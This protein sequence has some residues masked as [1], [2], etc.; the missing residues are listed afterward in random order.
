M[1]SIIFWKT[2]VYI[3]LPFMPRYIGTLNVTH[4]DIVTTGETTPPSPLDITE[5][6]LSPKAKSPLIPPSTHTPTRTITPL[7]EVQIDKNRHVTPQPHEQTNP[8]QIIPKWLLGRKTSISTPTSPVKQTTQPPTKRP[9]GGATTINY[10]LQEQ[11][12]REVFSPRHRRHKKTKSPDPLTTAVPTAP[13]PPIS[14]LTTDRRP[15]QGL[16]NMQSLPSLK[17]KVEEGGPLGRGHTSSLDLRKVATAAPSR[18]DT[19]PEKNP[20]PDPTGGTLRRRYSAGNL[21]EHSEEDEEKVPSEE[22]EEHLTLKPPTPP[23]EPRGSV[24]VPTYA[25]ARQNWAERCYQI[26]RSKRIEEEVRVAEQ[27]EETRTEWFLLIEN[28]TKNM[29]RPCV[30][31]LKM[32]TRQYGVHSSPEKRA[33]QRK[34]Y[35]PRLPGV[36]GAFGY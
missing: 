19:S 5:D 9:I 34:K 25:Q 1:G 32:G 7:P 14:P 36:V 12:L 6:D 4:R 10:K 16:T 31:D 35:N 22:D 11:V 24:V 13:D 23:P 15:S 30:L 3:V 28:L 18:V 8:C 26:E 21:R 2:N 29:I 27:G 17:K 20:S 33:S